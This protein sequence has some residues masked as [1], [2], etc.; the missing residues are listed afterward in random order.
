MK[1]L[2]PTLLTYRASAVLLTGLTA[3]A[4]VSTSISSMVAPQGGTTY[5]KVLVEFPLNDLGLRKAVEQRFHE[6]YELHQQMAGMKNWKTDTLFVPAYTML[7][8]GITYSRPK[9][10]SMLAAR[11]VEAILVVSL[12]ERG[13]KRGRIQ[14][15]TVHQCTQWTYYQCSAVSSNTYGGGNYSKPWTTYT[16]RL[17][18]AKTHE[19]MWVGSGRSGGNA[20]SS[21]ADLVRSIADKSVEQLIKD[22]LVT[23]PVRPRKG[24]QTTGA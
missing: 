5:R 22:G 21:G 15:T 16:V 10:D 7:F 19:V 24:E 1:G 2:M 13:E 20:F 12:G 14:G 23:K 3:S 11:D 9:L 4:C 8:P 17:Y 6:T 18:D